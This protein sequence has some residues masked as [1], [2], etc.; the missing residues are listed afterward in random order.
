M[1]LKGPEQGNHETVT[2]HQLP[3]G[4]YK[5]LSLVDVPS[6]YLTWLLTVKLSTG[7]KFAVTCELRNRGIAV[8]DPEPPRPVGPCPRCGDTGQVV[9][10]QEDS[11]GERRIRLECQRCRKLLKFAPQIA[12]YVELANATEGRD[13]A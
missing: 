12:P 9:S 3:F 7:L 1:V 10:W 5:G 4:K 11:R 6:D 2:T 8:P 13:H